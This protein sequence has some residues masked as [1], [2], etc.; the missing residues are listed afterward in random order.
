MAAESATL[1]RREMLQG[2]YSPAIVPMATPQGPIT[3]LAWALEIEDRYV[4]QLYGQV[5]EGVSA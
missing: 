4:E 2:G 5:N 3:A 1:W